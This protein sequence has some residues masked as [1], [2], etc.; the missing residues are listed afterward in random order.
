MPEI[1]EHWTPKRGKAGKTYPVRHPL[2]GSIEFEVQPVKIT[3]VYPADRSVQ[4][5]PDPDEGGTRSRTT[6]RV[7]DLRR[8]WKKASA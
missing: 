8:H 2:R 7:A 5:A 1:N 4:L 3:Q 6:V